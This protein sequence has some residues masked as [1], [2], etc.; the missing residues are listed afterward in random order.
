[1]NAR[2]RDL[3]KRTGNFA[4]A[5]YGSFNMAEVLIDQGH[6]DEA[7]AIVDEL[8]SLWR[9][10]EHTLGLAYLDGLAG[11]LAAR[12]G[13][14]GAA[15]EALRRAEESLAHHGLNAYAVEMAGRCAE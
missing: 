12:C 9:A 2:G 10:V 5:A 11:R 1:M 3:L 15:I 13:D 4:E 14:H 6:V 7:T 8:R